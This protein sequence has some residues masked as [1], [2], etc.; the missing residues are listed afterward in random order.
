MMHATIFAVASKA[1]V[2]GEAMNG[3]CCAALAN[4]NNMAPETGDQGQWQN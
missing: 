4:A 1:Y 2:S 3:V